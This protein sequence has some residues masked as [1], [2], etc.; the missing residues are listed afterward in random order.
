MLQITFQDPNGFY[1]RCR[2]THF[3]YMLSLSV[4]VG[5]RLSSILTLHWT[6]VNQ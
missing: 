3:M 6:G 2:L 1:F 5:N 4:V